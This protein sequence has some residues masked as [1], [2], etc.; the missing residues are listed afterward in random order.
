M[1]QRMF[2][3]LVSAGLGVAAAPSVAFLFLDGVIRTA[4]LAVWRGDPSAAG[5]AAGS[6]R[7]GAHAQRV[8]G[9]GRAS[10]PRARWWEFLLAPG[11]VR[12]DVPLSSVR[13]ALR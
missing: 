8:A 10:P 11:V 5:S 2:R 7:R 12:R 3:H 4:F 9:G 6:C 1:N 13:H